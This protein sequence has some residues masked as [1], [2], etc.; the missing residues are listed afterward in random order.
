MNCR[1]ITL[2]SLALAMLISLTACRIQTKNGENGENKNV[3]I[4]TPFGG[5]HVS[6][7]Q[8][9][10]ADIGLPTYPGAQLFHKK[11]D[12]NSSADVHMGFGKWQLRVKVV[13]Y[14]S[15]DSEEKITTF[16]KKALGRY[17][18]VITCRGENVVGTPEKTREGLTCKSEGRNSNMKVDD[19]NNH[20]SL[21]AGSP[22]RQHVVGI[23]AIENNQTH[24]ALIALDLPTIVEGPE[25]TN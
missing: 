23:R 14:T 11:G 10:A 22:T 21:K 2:F 17:G 8:T 12:S 19:S 20:L 5:L 15:P 24:F 4:D 3:K 18:D 9:A 13:E 16:Y 7:D 25:E 6:T 1:P